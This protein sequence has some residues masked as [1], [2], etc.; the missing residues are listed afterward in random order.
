MQP[1]EYLTHYNMEFKDY[2]TK[3]I[4]DKLKQVEEY[5]TK[6]G[7]NTITIAWRKWC[8]SPEYRKNEWQF[9][10]NVSEYAKYNAHKSFLK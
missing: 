10:Q 7:S 5:E 2:P 4:A 1:L 8:T 9:R 6:Y 3:Q